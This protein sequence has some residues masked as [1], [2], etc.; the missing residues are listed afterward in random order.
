MGTRKSA[1]KKSGT[2]LSKN[3]T[4]SSTK[5]SSATSTRA[6]RASKAQTDPTSLGMKDSKQQTALYQRS[7]AVRN[8]REGTS[9]P[10]SDAESQSGNEVTSSAPPNV[11]ERGKASSPMYDEVPVTGK[12]SRGVAVHGVGAKHV[13]AGLPATLDDMEPGTR[14]EKLSSNEVRIVTAIAGGAIRTFIG[15]TFREALIQLHKFL[16]GDSL[17]LPTASDAEAKAVADA[18]E[19]TVKEM[20]KGKKGAAKKSAAKK[21]GSKKGSKK[22]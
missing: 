22:K 14:I 6:A 12:D 4:T 19:A 1:A 18:N 21:A 2:R 10:L 3:S 7:L 13:P 20:K 16:R 9:D 17:T 8:Q 15:A 5:E 11:R